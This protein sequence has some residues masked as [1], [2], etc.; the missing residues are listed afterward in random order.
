VEDVDAE[1]YTVDVRPDDPKM[2]NL[3]KC[4][5][6]SPWA[7]ASAKIAFLPAVGEKVVI[8][9]VNGDNCLPYIE[10]FIPDTGSDSQMKL[11]WDVENSDENCIIAN[12][13]KMEIKTSEDLTI[14]ANGMEFKMTTT[15]NGKAIIL[16]PV[17]GKIKLGSGA[18]EGIIKGSL[19]QK[20]FESHT[21][22]GNNGAP[23]SPPMNKFTNEISE[24]A[25]VE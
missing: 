7:A 15:T 20:L 18:G 9:F 19:L 8:G 25:F 1:N 3:P 21:H 5:V 6:L 17:G 4:K 12:G 14:N 24:I 23:T 11:N 16:N 10:G 22:T 2:S 13:K